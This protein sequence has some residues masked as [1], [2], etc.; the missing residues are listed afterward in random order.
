MSK[1]VKKMKQVLLNL[2]STAQRIHRQM[3]YNTV[4]FKPDVA[5]EENVKLQAELNKA[6]AEAQE[7]IDSTH[8]DAAAAA[9][10][11]AEPAGKEINEDDLALL[12]GSFQLSSEDLHNLLAKYQDNGT[13]VNAIAAYAKKHD[14]ILDY[15]PNLEDKMFAYDSFAKSAYTMIGQICSSI[16]TPDYAGI[17]ALW[18]EPGNIGQRMEMALYGIKRKDAP[19]VTEP[20]AYFG[21]NFKPLKD[22]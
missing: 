10:K 19:P 22:R 15:I 13:M 5:G 11:W 21:F 2:N 18:A 17:L 8:E 1:Y 12:N 20:K 7:Q 9:R 3:D 4:N 14:I 6:G 16:G